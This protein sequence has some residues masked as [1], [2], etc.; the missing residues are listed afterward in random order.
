MHNSLEKKDCNFHYSKQLRS[1]PSP[2]PPPR[3]IAVPGLD[4]AS[5]APA[6]VSLYYPQT[7]KYPIGA[8]DI[9]DCVGFVLGAHKGESF[10][11]RS[12]VSN[13]VEER[14]QSVRIESYN[15][16]VTMTRSW[17]PFLSE[18]PSLLSHV[19][20][21]CAPSVIRQDSQLGCLTDQY[22]SADGRCQR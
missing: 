16:L 6:T 17:T 12:S 18:R 22:Q 20:R 3:R 2:V 4:R 14:D 13:R 9:K 7:P 1:P 10:N 11:L 21:Q 8:P 19:H 5:S 15:S